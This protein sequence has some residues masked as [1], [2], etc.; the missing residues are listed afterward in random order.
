M[1]LKEELW[2]EAQRKLQDMPAVMLPYP[3]DLWQGMRDHHIWHHASGA[4]HQ[5][6]VNLVESL[7]DK[8]EE[9]QNRITQL[10][11]GKH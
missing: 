5:A 2:R 8:V 1:S 3:T 4:R 6:L 9:L 10:E 7:V 11:E